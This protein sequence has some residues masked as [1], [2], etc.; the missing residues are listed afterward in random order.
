M[1]KVNELLTARKQAL[2]HMTRDTIEAIEHEDGYME[3]LVHILEADTDNLRSHAKAEKRIA[4]TGRYVRREDIGKP[5]Q[6]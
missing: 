4:R 5:P 2:I 3:H 1:D 6:Y